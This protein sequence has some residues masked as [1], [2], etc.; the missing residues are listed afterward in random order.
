MQRDESGKWRSESPVRA[1]MTVRM[2]EE[3][4]DLLTTIAQEEGMSPTILARQII[5][6]WLEGHRQA[7][8]SQKAA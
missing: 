8:K 7:S 6:E 4:K 2:T 5:A 1:T 3:D